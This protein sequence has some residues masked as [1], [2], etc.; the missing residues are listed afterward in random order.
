MNA[1]RGAGLFAAAGLAEIGVAV[2]FFSPGTSLR[3]SAAWWRRF[4]AARSR[5]VPGPESHGSHPTQ[6]CV[7][8]L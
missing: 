3:R 4:A 7:L 6:H 8:A 5:C 2:I 1:L